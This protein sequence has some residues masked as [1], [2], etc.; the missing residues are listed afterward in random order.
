[1]KRRPVY[2]PYTVYRWLES[3]ISELLQLPYVGEIRAT[4]IRIR[5]NT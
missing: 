1:M 2:L 5:N 3:T 4:D